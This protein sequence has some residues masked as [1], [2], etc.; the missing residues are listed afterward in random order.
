MAETLIQWAGTPRPDGTIIPGYT[1][2]GWIGCTHKSPGCLNCYAEDLD[3][4]RFS[5]TLGGGTK[6]V[7]VSH[8]GKGRP[9]Y[10]TSETNWKQPYNW[11]RKAKAD[12]IRYRVFCSSLSDWLD[13]EVPIEWLADLL[14]VIN[15][16]PY[17]DW[18]M[19]T[20]RPENFFERVEDAR[21]T[22]RCALDMLSRWQANQ[23]PANVWVGTSTEDQIRA[24]E[25]IPLVSEIPALLRFL[26]CEPLI[27]PLDLSAFLRLGWSI[28]QTRNEDF[29]YTEVPGSGHWVHHPPTIIPE[30]MWRKIHW[31]I[32]GGES[33]IST[34][35]LHPIRPMHPD[36]ARLLR[37]QCQAAKVPFFFKQWGRYVPDPRDP[38]NIALPERQ[39][40][41][42]LCRDGSIH[43][44]SWNRVHRPQGVMAMHDAGKKSAF[45]ELDGREWNEFPAVTST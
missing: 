42:A 12:G 3:D 39:G 44:G 38:E 7:P 5:K 31:V 32:A 18:L 20:K 37:D 24:D 27:G 28:T 2:N 8:W 1:F 11:N 16:T 14:G 6:E 41:L 33:G 43:N 26:S 10:R 25:R 13:K 36:W 9:R 15:D 30:A 40:L 29:T 35:P 45:R 17:L 19:L 4:N 22:G 23:P 34:N 21:L